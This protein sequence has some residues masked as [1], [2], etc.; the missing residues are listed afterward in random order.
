MGHQQIVPMVHSL[1][2][3]KAKTRLQPFRLSHEEFL[4]LST[5]LSVLYAFDSA[6]APSIINRRHHLHNTLNIHDNGLIYMKNLP[7]LY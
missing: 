3:V 6:Y 2:R 4:H 7:F 5:F 1:H